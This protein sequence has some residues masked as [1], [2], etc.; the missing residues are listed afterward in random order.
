MEKATLLNRPTE[1]LS[2][3]NVRLTDTPTVTLHHRWPVRVL[4]P[5]SG[6]GQKSRQ[7]VCS[8]GCI[9]KD[10]L[11]ADGVYDNWQISSAVGVHGCNPHSLRQLFFTQILEDL[12]TELHPESRLSVGDLE[13]LLAG[14]ERPDQVRRLIQVLGS[15]T[16][17]WSPPQTF[18]PFGRYDRSVTRNEPGGREPGSVMWSILWTRSWTTAS[19]VPCGS[20]R[21]ERQAI[22]PSDGRP[23]AP[24]QTLPPLPPCKGETVPKFKAPS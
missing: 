3:R 6:T 24:R 13:K 8:R 9:L 17:T 16:R 4:G 23:N 7:L 18:S 19:G 10:V 5:I 11:H 21:E 1:R 14:R 2:V 22:P 20:L 12:K 15:G